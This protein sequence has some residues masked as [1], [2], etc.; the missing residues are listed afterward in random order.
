MQCKGGRQ[1]H[2]SPGTPSDREGCSPDRGL[3]ETNQRDGQKYDPYGAHDPGSHGH[4]V[5]AEAQVVQVR[6]VLQGQ[7]QQGTQSHPG[8]AAGHKGCSA[9]GGVSES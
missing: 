9:Q 4:G 3:L 8:S 2:I 5:E 1:D 6:E 7:G